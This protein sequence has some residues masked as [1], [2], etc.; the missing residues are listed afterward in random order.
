[1]K[2][3]IL[4]LMIT[5]LF[6]FLSIFADNKTAE[7]TLPEYDIEKE[8]QLI[9]DVEN[10]L[11]ENSFKEGVETSFDTESE[12]KDNLDEVVDIFQRSKV[13]ETTSYIY[14]STFIL[15]DFET[16]LPIIEAVIYIDDQTVGVTD[17]T[18]TYVLS[19]DQFTSYALEIVHPDYHKLSYSDDYFKAPI[20]NL[21]MIKI[22]EKIASNE[23]VLITE[24]HISSLDLETFI[25]DFVDIE[26]RKGFEFNN[27]E[28][29]LRQ[30]QMADDFNHVVIK[31][32]Y[33]SPIDVAEI[34]MSFGEGV[35]GLNSFYRGSPAAKKGENT[36]V[37]VILKESIGLPD[38]MIN[39]EL[40]DD[41]PVEIPATTLYFY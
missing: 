19:F 37:F 30:L 25:L 21:N 18:G 35:E 20:M 28:F 3:T 34:G 39:L 24:K 13:A 5:I 17:K 9:D 4:V 23:V 11:F 2:K 32:T 12:A 16:G 40:G 15:K 26:P 33:Y 8:G 41:N 36:F 10:T 29:K 27:P 22:S 1:M 14:G 31:V 6:V 38:Y 7:V